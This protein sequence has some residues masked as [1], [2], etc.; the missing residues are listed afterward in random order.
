MSRDNPFYYTHPTDPAEFVGRWSQVE[1]IAADLSRPRADSWA[2]IG[3]RRFGKTSLLIVLES[4]LLKRQSTDDWCILPIFMDLAAIGDART[5]GV[6][7]E[8]IVRQ[9]YRALEK[10]DIGIS[11]TL[12]RGIAAN[13]V[14][15]FSFYQFGDTLENLSY[16]IGKLN[17]QLRLVLLLDETEAIIHLPW[18]STFFAQ[19]RALVS[20]RSLSDIVRL[21]LAGSTEF[22]HALDHSSPLW[23]V[24]RLI[25]LE[26][27]SKGD[28]QKL[29]LSNGE[30]SSELAALVHEQSG[31]HP[32]IAQYLLHHLWEEGLAR[33]TPSQVEHIAATM[34]QTRAAD[35]QDWWE[36]VGESGRL[37]YA[38]LVYTEGWVDE[39][40][41][42]SQIDSTSQLPAQG[43]AAICYHGLAIRDGK[44]QRYRVAGKL[45]RN[46]FLENAAQIK[47]YNPPAIQAL[48]ATDF[49]SAP[50]IAQVAHDVTGLPEDL[51]F[52]G[53]AVAEVLPRLLAVSRDVNTALASDSVYNR[54][55]GLSHAQEDL[56][57]LR[58]R[59]PLI[60]Q[61]AMQRWQP[62]VDSWVQVLSRELERP[63]LEFRTEVVN[64]YDAGNP[65]TLRR[66]ALF[67]GRRD[68]TEAMAR[69]LLER[70]RPTLVLHGPRRMGKTSFLLQLPRLLLG[71]TVPAFID[72]QRPAATAST[73]RFLYAVTHAIV[74][75][76]RNHS[77]LILPMPGHETFEHKPFVTFADWLDEVVPAKLEEAGDTGVYQSE[78]YSLYSIYEVGLRRLL[79]KIGRD[80]PRYS[81]A[82]TYQQRMVESIRQSRR[83]GDTATRQAERTE[84]ID[85]LNA[86]ALSALQ[87]SFNELLNSAST[88]EEPTERKL[89]G[90]TLFLCFDEFEKLGQAV[91]TGRVDER[92]LDELRHTIQ[93]REAVSLLFAGV[94]TLE[95]L[96]PHWSS[97]FINVRPMRITYLRR[98]EATD[99]VRNPDP[100][101]GF[102]L[103]YAD[104]A[105]EDILAATCCHPFLVQLVCSAV[106]NLANERRTL[107][108]TSDLVQDAQTAALEMGEPYF[109]NLWDE[110]TG[111][112]TEAVAA[113]RAILRQVAVSQEP[114][115]VTADAPAAARALERLLRHDVLERIG[116]GVQFQ[117]PLVKR[118]VQEHA[119]VG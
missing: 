60:G 10:L 32:F 48:L 57:A 3:G 50:D 11:E 37:A 38:L 68:L 49:T 87:V 67:R 19:L 118:W 73:A 18:S 28:L 51:R 108:A 23:N 36:T 6:A 62:V 110:S 35:F 25:Y 117:V 15:E 34:L 90:F 39:Q 77:R 29:I 61:K 16:S 115:A 101:S 114:V 41:L 26:P 83:Y 94:Q 82:L 97:Y 112:D 96:G 40:A 8:R 17:K 20:S 95:E 46:W 86:L 72:L 1:R 52:L 84:I 33:A 24:L 79:D 113:G 74:N 91:K 119:P 56:N 27:I 75:D 12:M 92:V 81:E 78:A 14:T 63:I 93:H 99:L 45:F 111:G 53:A 30:T 59:L 65:I 71:R 104:E 103:E 80:H 105:V 42:L 13:K 58:Q 70:N 85:Q 66:A 54:R 31:G 100:E 21:V 64:P 47:E 88:G 116:D 9:A 98:E 106:V 2:I 4:Q 5:E 55:L 89:G 22:I 43:L 107:L 44:E 76:A 7:Y 69:A 109:R 102:N